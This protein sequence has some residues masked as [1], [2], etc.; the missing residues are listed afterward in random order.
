MN[1][2][3]HLD[4][5]H[6]PP[7]RSL[8]GPVVFLGDGAGHWRRWQTSFP[9]QRYD[10]GSVAVA[11]F[12]GDGH[13]DIALGMHLLGV[14]VLLGDGA[15]RFTAASQGLDPLSPQTAFS[16]RALVAV[17]WDGDG[18][19]DLIALGEGP[20]FVPRRTDG[21]PPQV[22][23]GV[24]FYRNR[25]DATWEKRGGR[26]PKAGDALV[27]APRRSGERP[28]LVAGSIET[29]LRD[30]V[31]RPGTPVT[32]ETLPGVRA[33]ALVRTVAIADFDGDGHDDVAVAYSS[34][35]GRQWRSGID[36]V[37]TRPDR[38]AQRRTLYVVDGPRG[39]ATLAAGDLDGDGWSDLVA[40][41]GHGEVLVL[42]NAGDGV[43]TR[44]DAQLSERAAGC[45]GYHVEVRDLDKDGRADIVASFAGE[46]VGVG[47]DLGEPGCPEQ[48]SLRAWRSRSRS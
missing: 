14:T 27:L 20:R 24:V 2:D 43:F 12:N 6:G 19:V 29:G 28:W 31:L 4:I 46:P 48:G 30:L 41:S 39:I 3:G 37:L 47:G 1:R 34:H 17:D 18:H 45:Q 22:S 9:A 26:E 40:L 35:E 10:Y 13:L 5:V 23:A 42:R 33:R 16:S 15:G 21:S 44:E 36:V 7:R 32:V 38:A 8:G 11:D 25:G